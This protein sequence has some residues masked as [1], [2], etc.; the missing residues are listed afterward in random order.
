MDEDEKRRR[1]CWGLGLATGSSNRYLPHSDKVIGVSSEQ[2]LTV[3]GPGKGQTL[4]RLSTGAS[5]NLRSEV[6]DHVLAFKVPDLDGGAGGSAQPVSV[7]REAQAVDGIGVLKGVKM[8]SV[9]QIPKHSL[10]VLSTGGAEGAVG[11]H[12]D[13]VKVASVADVVGLQLAVG[14]VPHLN[15]FVPSS[16]N[17]DGVLVVGGESHTGNPVTVSVL[18]DGVLALGKSVPKLDGLIP[19]SGHDLSVVSREGDRHDVL[20][21]VLEPSGALSGLQVPQSEGLV[22]RS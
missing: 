21:V 4:G 11:G 13:G 15:V 7:G 8:L 19:G 14:K 2:S 18:L 3:S 10:G 12:G 16:G 22:P 9:I 6:F 20:G 1:R 17:N 5:G